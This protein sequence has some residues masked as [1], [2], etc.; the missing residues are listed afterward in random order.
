MHNSTCFSKSKAISI[1]LLGTYFYSVGTHH[2]I[3]L[4]SLVTMSIG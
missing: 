1:P 3:V 2:E 4:N